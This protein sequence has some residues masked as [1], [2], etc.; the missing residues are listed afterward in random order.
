MHDNTSMEPG[1]L[2]DA[3]DG[4]RSAMN[5]VCLVTAESKSPRNHWVGV[6]GCLPVAAGHWGLKDHL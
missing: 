2:N 3:N 6:S 1:Y 4:G 5:A